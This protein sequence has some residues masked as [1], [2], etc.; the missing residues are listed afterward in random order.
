MKV[1]GHSR[2]GS[3][4]DTEVY[5]PPETEG[6]AEGFVIHPAFRPALDIAVS[7]G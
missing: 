5:V 3:R 2:A 7:N 1:L 6:H 4:V